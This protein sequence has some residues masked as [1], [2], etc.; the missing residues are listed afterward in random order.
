MEKPASMR[1]L[2][3]DFTSTYYNYNQNYKIDVKWF[4]FISILNVNKLDTYIFVSRDL[5]ISAKGQSCT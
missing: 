2:K 1:H 4:F 3:L 5:V